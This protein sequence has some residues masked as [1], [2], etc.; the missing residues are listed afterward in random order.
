MYVAVGKET[1]ISTKLKYWRAV[2]AATALVAVSGCYAHG[3]GGYNGG[4]YGERGENGE[5]G[6]R[7]ERG[8]GGERGESGER[9]ERGA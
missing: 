1:M 9:G 8:D 4:Y 5:R 7:G 3:H 2:G 6:E